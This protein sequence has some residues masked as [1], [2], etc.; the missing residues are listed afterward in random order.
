MFVRFSEALLQ[1]FRVLRRKRARRDGRQRPICREGGPALRRGTAGAPLRSSHRWPLCTQ[2]K[3]PRLYEET[4]GKDCVRR[5]DTEPSPRRERTRAKETKKGGAFFSAAFAADAAEK[6]APRHFKRAQR[7]RGREGIARPLFICSSA[8]I[9]MPSA[10][11][12]AP[13]LYT[14]YTK[15]ACR[16]RRLFCCFTGYSVFSR[17]ALW[18]GSTP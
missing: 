17:S 15:S 3:A 1:A 18:P 14:S 5:R 13:V 16:S 8:M 9:L 10:A 12:D 7:G 6:K 4:R 11:K 2:P